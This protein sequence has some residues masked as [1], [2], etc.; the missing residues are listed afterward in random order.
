MLAGTGTGTGTH[1]AGNGLQE[2]RLQEVTHL[3]DFYS[4]LPYGAATIVG[5]EEDGEG[6]TISAGN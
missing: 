3:N 2:S 1:D 6:Y 4:S 5:G